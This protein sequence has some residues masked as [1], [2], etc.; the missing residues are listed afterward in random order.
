VE[1]SDPT[2]I[3]MVGNLSV[4]STSVTFTL[5]VD[6]EAVPGERTVTAVSPSGRSDAIPFTVR[7][8]NPTITRMA[9]VIV[10]SDRTYS[11]GTIYSAPKDTFS[12][13][14]TDLIGVNQIDISP[15]GGLTLAWSNRSTSLAGMLAV[16]ANAVPSQRQLT[17]SSPGGTSNAFTF[18]VQSP[19]ATAPVITSATLGTPVI[20]AYSASIKYTGKITFTDADGD[21]QMGSKCPSTY[22]LAI[23]VQTGCPFVRLTAVSGASWAS[24]DIAGPFLDLPGQNGGDIDFT[25]TIGALSYVKFGVSKVAVTLYDA[26]GHPS[27]SVVV[28][29]PT[30]MVPAI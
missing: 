1:F 3:R 19:P 4:S 30:W 24:F 14:G 16:D 2:G 25:T 22:F 17:V 12:I 6:G 11:T 26:A 27:N 23:I 8:G 18:N 15:P 20:P 21:I 28:D 29:A 9:P 5:S 13:Q 7:R 10:Y